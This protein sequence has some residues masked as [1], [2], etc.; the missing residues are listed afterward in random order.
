MQNK[1]TTYYNRYFKDSHKNEVNA[2]LHFINM[3]K[4]NEGTLAVFKYDM[5]VIQVHTSSYKQ[6]L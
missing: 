2:S 1:N 3:S 5:T 6:Q 4:S